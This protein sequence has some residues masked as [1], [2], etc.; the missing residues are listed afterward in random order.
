MGFY[1]YF[2]Y[3]YWT[4]YIQYKA[5]TGGGIELKL[6]STGSQNTGNLLKSVRTKVILLLI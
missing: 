5:W 1:F 3:T 4:P 6:D 2:I